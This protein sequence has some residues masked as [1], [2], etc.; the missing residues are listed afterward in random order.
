MSRKHCKILF[1]DL[2]CR[3]YV[4]D[5][6][7]KFGTLAASDKKPTEEQYFKDSVILQVDRHVISLEKIKKKSLFDKVFK[8][9][10]YQTEEA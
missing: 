4:V 3:F 10:S 5:L 1:D 2:K 8:I 7:S 9:C 6:D